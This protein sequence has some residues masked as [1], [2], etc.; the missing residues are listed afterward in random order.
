VTVPSRYGLFTP[1]RHQVAS[2]WTTR[3]EAV[4]TAV[5]R[6]TPQFHRL[7][8]LKLAAVVCQSTGVLARSNRQ[9]GDSWAK[10]PTS[11]GTA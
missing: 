10:T 9:S 3:D 8:A 6:L 1:N 7:L 11:G 5:A 2:S 4:K